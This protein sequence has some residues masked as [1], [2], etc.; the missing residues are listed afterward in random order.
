M[1]EFVGGLRDPYKVVLPRATLLSLGLRIRA[2]WEAFERK[3]KDAHEVAEKYGTPDCEMS[4]R[5]V[6][7]W[8]AVLRKTLGAQAPPKVKMRPR[9]NYVSPLDAELLEAWIAKGGDPDDVIPKWIRTGAPLG[10]ETPI[11]TKGI[12]PRNVDS[13]NMDYH[14]SHELEDAGAQ[15]SH[16]D[17]QN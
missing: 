3:H 15:M 10:I 8:K 17:I 13:S 2:A 1:L 7:E 11:E 5:L 12:F 6:S 4:E 9:W 16:G 14:G